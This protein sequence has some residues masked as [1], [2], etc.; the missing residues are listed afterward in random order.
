MIGGVLF[1][2]ST[3]A[4]AIAPYAAT[5][6]ASLLGVMWSLSRRETDMSPGHRLRG[7]LFVVKIIGAA[8]VVTIP[9]ATW[10]SPKLGLDTDSYAVAPIGFLIGAVGEDWRPFLI[11]V[12]DF[13]LRWKSGT[14][15]DDK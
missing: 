1:S 11:W 4:A 3:L 10:V 6:F 13:I 7:V 8:M 14:I 15:G 12:R 2:N 5:F 9:L